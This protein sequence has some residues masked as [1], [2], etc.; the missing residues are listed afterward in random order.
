MDGRIDNRERSRGLNKKV[1]VE[2]ECV[3][4]LIKSSVDLGFDNVFDW[5]ICLKG[6]WI[7]W[8]FNGFCLDLFIFFVFFKEGFCFKLLNKWNEFYF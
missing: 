6:C 2:L 3:I 1:V 5:I 8:F 7:D 4:F